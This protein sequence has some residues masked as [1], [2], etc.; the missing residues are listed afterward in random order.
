M[1][2]KDS[3]K[4]CKESPPKEGCPQDGVGRWKN[5]SSSKNLVLTHINATPIYR[6]FTAFLP[7]EKRLN[8]KAR[9]LR[10]TGNKPEIV[11]WQQVHKGKFHHINFDRQRVIGS[12]IVDFYVKGLSLIIEI[13][14]ASHNDKEVYDKKRENYLRSLGLGIYRISATDVMMDVERV[15][16]LLEEYIIERYSR[17]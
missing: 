14:G 15:M 3:K 8:L 10:K 11:F 7:R 9:S 2:I 1:S 4:G 12:Y 6:N 5:R 17:P 13:D 16:Q